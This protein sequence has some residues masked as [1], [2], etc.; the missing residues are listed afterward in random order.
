MHAC[1]HVAIILSVVVCMYVLTLLGHACIQ[2]LCSSLTFL[3]VASPVQ[4]YMFIMCLIDQ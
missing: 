2:C 1:V 4:V 3:G